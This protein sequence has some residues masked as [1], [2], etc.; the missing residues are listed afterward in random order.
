LDHFILFKGVY[1]RH[2]D[3]D[4]SEDADRERYA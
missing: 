2:A 4:T 1:S 3:Y